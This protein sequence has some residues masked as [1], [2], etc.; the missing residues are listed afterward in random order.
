M[1][2][3][4]RTSDPIDED[5]AYEMNRELAQDEQREIDRR[6]EHARTHCATH[7]LT[8]PCGGCLA[9]HFAGEHP[10]I[11]HETCE[12]CQ[13]ARR[14]TPPAQIDAVSLAAA[15]DSLDSPNEGA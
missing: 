4:R 5:I 10:L 9:D 7:H 11:D 15:D 2:H 6:V 12:R 13:R 8:L 3:V 14:A 1:S